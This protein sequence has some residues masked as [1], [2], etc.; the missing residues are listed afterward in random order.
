MWKF[1]PVKAPWTGGVYE[2]LI[3]NLK[4]NLDKMN[5]NQIINIEEFREHIYECERVIN[6]RPLQQVGENEVITPSMLLYG[7]KL[8]GGGTLSSLYVD[9]L[10]EDSKYLQKI[11]PQIY[12]DNIR[13]KRFWEAFQADYLDSL[14]LSGEPPKHGDLRSKRI[15]RV[16]DLIMIHD[17]DARIKPKRAF[18]LETLISDDGGIRSCK[19]RIGTNESIRPVSSFRDLELNVYDAYQHQ[20]SDGEDHKISGITVNHFKKLNGNCVPDIIEPI[21][22]ENLLIDPVPQK[23]ERKCKIKARHLIYKHFS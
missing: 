22:Q 19:V 16:G 10:L 17:V 15:P 20:D 18:I 6:D 8:G 1:I 21:D 14:R 23:V 4:A 13:R 2:R 11:L 12:M 9:N 3:G 5:M 7:R